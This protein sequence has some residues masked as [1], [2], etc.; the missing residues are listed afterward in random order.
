M[1][2]TPLDRRQFL[3]RL[4]IATGATLGLSPLRDLRAADNP[5][6]PLRVII[7]GAGLAGLC[8]AYEL[9][10]RGHDVVLLEAERRHIGG[11]VRTLRFEDGLYGEAGAMRIPKRHELTRHYVREA[12]VSLRP[13]VHSNPN[14]YYYL[15]GRRERIRDGKR[16]NALFQ[17]APR[18][19]DLSAD[20]LWE[21]AVLRRLAALTEA[22]R[23]ELSAVTPGSTAV[24]ALDNFSLQQLCDQAG[25]S[26]EAIE[27]LSVI[28]GQEAEMHT[29][30]TEFLREERNEVWTQEFDEIVGGTDRLPAALAQ[31]L[32]SR[33]KLGCEVVRLEQDPLRG[34]A[35]A[36]YR[37]DGR[38]RR[39]EGDFLLCT[40]PFPVL[41]RLRIEPAFS[42]G[43]QRA[44]RQLHY[45]SSTKVLA[46]AKRRFWETDDGI[47]GGGTFT[48][49]PSGTTYYPSSNAAARDP[50]VSAAASPFLA[51]YT[52]GQAARRLGDLPHAERA[53]LVLENLAR[54]HPQLSDKALIRRTASWSWDEHRWSGGAFAWFLPGQHTGLHAD[55]IKPEGRIHFAG[56]HA[57]L[58]HTWMQGAL[59]SAV[60]AVTA[61]LAAASR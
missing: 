32:R 56:E 40:L 14:G 3:R 8:A 23:A 47:Y 27:L 15:R 51:S 13:F 45:D 44:I 18:E 24:R 37:E 34:K 6:R 60:S 54:V 31:K 42:S 25:W 2:G 46:I 43:K 36:I 29:G 35:A 1:H 16:L 26:Q 9:E 48:D 30:A 28:Y 61:M 58:T 7:V 50:A 53:R 55:I 4:G 33:P 5:G 17:L 38:E 39:V 49:L 41:A 20:D 52:W 19:R 11:R 21:A 12:G 59:E 10:R 57:S 22:E